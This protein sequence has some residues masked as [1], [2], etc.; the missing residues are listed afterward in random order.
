MPSGTNSQG[1]H[2]NTP[3]GTNSNTG[4]S[5]H[6]KYVCFLHRRRLE[7]VKTCPR[8]AHARKIPNPNPRSSHRIHRPR[9]ECIVRCFGALVFCVLHVCNNVSL[10]ASCFCSRFL[11]S[12][13]KTW[14]VPQIPTRTVAIT[15]AMTM[16][17]NITTRA[18]RD[19][20][21]TRLLLVVV[22][23]EDVV[24]NKVSIQ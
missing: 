17:A 24:A 16:V 5:Y 15:T 1:N 22:V 23:V 7:R 2:Y 11:V 8:G 6:C 3:G 10:I 4:S 14:H 9:I 18:A 13:A 12:G 19:T 21:T 20:P